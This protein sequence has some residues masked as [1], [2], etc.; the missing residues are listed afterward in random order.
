[1]TRLAATDWFLGFPVPSR[2]LAHRTPRAY[3]RQ[4]GHSCL[5]VSA[6]PA[7]CPLCL[8]L[9]IRLFSP[10]FAPLQ[11]LSLFLLDL[12]HSHEQVGQSGPMARAL[13]V[14]AVHRT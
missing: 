3:L 7:L 8:H 1:M 14:V 9:P 5:A 2:S 13:G 10:T 11:D 12:I 4:Y 6:I